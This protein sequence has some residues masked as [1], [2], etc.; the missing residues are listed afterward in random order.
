LT[1][2][3]GNRARLICCEPVRCGFAFHGCADNRST[4]VFEVLSRVAVLQH[5]DHLR[6]ADSRPCSMQTSLQLGG[7]CALPS[8][9]VK[10]L[11]F[12]PA[13]SLT[14][15]LQLSLIT[16]IRTLWDGSQPVSSDLIDQNVAYFSRARDSYTRI[17]CH[18]SGRGKR[19]T[20]TDPDMHFTGLWMAT[21]SARR[22][23]RRGTTFKGGL[24][25]GSS[26]TEHRPSDPNTGYCVTK[27]HQLLAVALG[28]CKASF[29]SG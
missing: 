18:S 12:A 19:I 17:W 23:I 21:I 29:R 8:G 9:K 10:E 5:S 13:F 20:L 6:F 25:L 1:R 3:A 4:F 28:Y 16:T 27:A 11:D 26:R 14:L 15:Q 2:Q 7:Q 22:Q 24:P